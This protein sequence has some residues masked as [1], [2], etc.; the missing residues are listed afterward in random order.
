MKKIATLTLG[1]LIAATAGYAQTFDD[2][3]ETYTTGI[4]LGPQSTNWT[5]WSLADTPA[6][7]VNVITTDNHTS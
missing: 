6:E 2:D 3:F 5:T 7:D 1:C 4:K